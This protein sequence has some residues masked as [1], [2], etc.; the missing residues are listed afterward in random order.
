MY[1]AILYWKT[2]QQPVTFASV[3]F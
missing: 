2:C 1:L 3:C